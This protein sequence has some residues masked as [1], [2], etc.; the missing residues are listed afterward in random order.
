MGAIF[1]NSLLWPPRTDLWMPKCLLVYMCT[2]FGAFYQKG[3][4]MLDYATALSHFM[5]YTVVKL[6]CKNTAQ[7][8]C[9]L[10]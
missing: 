10:L 8:L 6:D 3:H 1:L 5:L 4:N 7:D 2:N 9:Y